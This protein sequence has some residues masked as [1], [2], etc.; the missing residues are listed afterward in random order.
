MFCF[1][2]RYFYP[3]LTQTP[4]SNPLS[5]GSTSPPPPT[6]L[7]ELSRR[8]RRLGSV[9]VACLGAIANAVVA[10]CGV[11]APL[12]RELARAPPRPSVTGAD[13]CV[14]PPLD[15]THTNDTVVT[16]LSTHVVG[17]MAAPGPDGG[18]HVWPIAARKADQASRAGRMQVDS[19]GTTNG[20]KLEDGFGVWDP[21]L[22]GSRKGGII[23]FFSA[24]LTILQ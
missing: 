2:D 20:V 17:G 23:V 16:A 6:A 22:S 18:A 1:M 12:S 15:L 10:P 19:G 4:E 13:G 14:A 5:L 11:A 9:A 24:Q 7:H 3:C 21:H 8:A